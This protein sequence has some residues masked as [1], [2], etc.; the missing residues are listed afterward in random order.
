MW[1]R[2]LVSLVKKKNRVLSMRGFRPIAVLPTTLRSCSE[3]LQSLEGS[4]LK[5]RRGPKS[6]VV[7]HFSFSVVLQ[8]KPQNGKFP[9][10][11]W[12]VM[13][14]LLLTMFLTM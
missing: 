12:T 11:L 1:S 9:S 3:I 5:S 13:L 10:F 7:K 2:L 4:A 6:R 14:Q 8:N